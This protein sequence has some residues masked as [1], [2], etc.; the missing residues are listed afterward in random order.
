MR[1]PDPLKR[2]AAKEQLFVKD[3]RQVDGDQ[4]DPRKPVAGDV[5]KARGEQDQS[6]R[7][8]DEQDC[9]SASDQKLG[10]GQTPRNEDA[11]VPR[12]VLEDRD[13]P[14]RRHTD[15]QQRHPLVEKRADRFGRETRDEERRQV[16]RHEE[17]ERGD[18]LREAAGAVC[19]DTILP[20]E[21][22]LTG[23][24]TASCQSTDKSVCATPALP[25][26]SSCAR[27]QEWCGTDTLV[28]A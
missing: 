1:L 2:I 4:L 6:V 20:R 21:M 8:P 3:R 27:R 7:G 28:C 16:K 12:G 19:L 18:D 14:E 17:A 26:I 24:A 15:T 23:S 11:E 13:R 22:R 25:F 10:R 9:G 5:V